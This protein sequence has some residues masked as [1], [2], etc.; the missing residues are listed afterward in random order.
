[1]SCIG[2]YLLESD[3]LSYRMKFL[4]A[5]LALVLLNF[6]GVNSDHMRL[7]GFGKHFATS[8]GTMIGGITEL[9]YDID[10]QELVAR[11]LFRLADNSTDARGYLF[12][13]NCAAAHVDKLALYNSTEYV[14]DFEFDMEYSGYRAEVNLMF[15][16][17]SEELTAFMVESGTTKYCSEIVQRLSKEMDFIGDVHYTNLDFALYGTEDLM[18]LTALSTFFDEAATGMDTVNAYLFSGM[19]CEDLSNSSLEAGVNATYVAE[20][21]YESANADGFFISSA[22]FATSELVDFSSDVALVIAD[23][24]MNVL[25]CDLVMASMEL[26]TDEPSRTTSAPSVGPKGEL[27][28]E[29]V[30]SSSTAAPAMLAAA[31]L[32]LLA[33]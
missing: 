12:N 19:Y 15:D 6:Y 28:T 9:Q 23:S 13:G 31:V 14:V 22:D 30:S 4:F 17:V 7:Y 2:I 5:V 11:S 10:T 24:E 32:A 29:Y 1:V 20:F 25:R 27:P 18:N 26:P 16:N 8:T 33:L 3:Y 21:S